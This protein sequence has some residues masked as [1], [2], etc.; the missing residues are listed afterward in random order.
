MC[1]FQAWRF[2]LF[3]PQFFRKS[4]CDHEIIPFLINIGEVLPARSKA[5]LMDEM[6]M[7]LIECINIYGKNLRKLGKVNRITA[8]FWPV[9]LVPLN[10][11]RACVCSY[12]LNKQE[13]LNVGK[14]NQIP[15]N[16]D[17]IIKGADSVSF[18]NALQ[19]YNSTYL[20]KSKNFRRGT[21]IQEALFNSNEVD[22]FKNFFL[23]QYSISSFNEPYFL[24]EGGPIP[25]SINQA[26]I[27][28]EIH[29]QQHIQ[30]V[31]GV[32]S[33]LTVPGQKIIFSFSLSPSHL[34]NM[35]VPC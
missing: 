34:R 26:N 32:L 4:E 9:R 35:K 33:E 6:A 16:P 18:L 22:Y 25:K 30:N 15:P 10:E 1:Y 21:V 5:T 13:R 2:L 8:C 11:T 24:L 17:N 31:P 29:H 7:A 20:K 14:F 27:V 12:L 3:F 23:N 28:P 19:S